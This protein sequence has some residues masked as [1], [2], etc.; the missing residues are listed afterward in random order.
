ML[1]SDYEAVMGS[2]ANLTTVFA[3]ADDW[4]SPNLT[5]EEDR[6]D[7][8][9]HAAEFDN[10]LAFAYSVVPV[11][12]ADHALPE[13]IGC[14][15]INPATRKGYDAEIHLWTISHGVSDSEAASLESELEYLVKQWL[16]EVWPF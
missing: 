14:V 3:P 1:A 6:V 13:T 12:E 2:A 8:T 5:I 9:R 4:P 7:L 15:Y 10:R 11:D 16:K